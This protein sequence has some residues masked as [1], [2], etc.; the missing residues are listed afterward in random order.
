MNAL[1]GSVLEFVNGFAR[2]SGTFDNLM[3][4][5]ATNQLVKSGPLFAAYCYAWFGTGPDTERRRAVVLAAFAASMVGLFVA[6]VLAV[7]L[8][9]RTRPID[10]AA[11]QF[12][13][14]YG[15]EQISLTTWSSFPSDHAVLYVA[16]AGGIFALWRSLGW[17]ALGYVVVVVLLP[18]IYLGVHF[19]TDI[20]AGAVIGALMVWA[21]LHES[22][23]QPLARRA[24]P[25]CDR[26]PAWFY[27]AAFIF[28]WQMAMLFQ[29]P[30]DLAG[31]S[32]AVLGKL[33]GL[34]Y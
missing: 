3:Y 9:L 8:P 6:R 18:R 11:L 16:L 4:L 19:T 29:D 24:L 34:A 33:I 7:A 21:A 1:D 23:R 14:P 17:L 20:L 13:H 32:W 5:I 28:A 30:R 26:H 25:W 12:V 10:D 27:S 15:M 22:V 31:F 2:R